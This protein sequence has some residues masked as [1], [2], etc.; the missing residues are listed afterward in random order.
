MSESAS[1]SGTQQSFMPVAA[2]QGGTSSGGLASTGVRTAAPLG[3]AVLLLGTGAWLMTWAR[4][5]RRH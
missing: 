3:L 1:A 5:P 2:Q 4:R